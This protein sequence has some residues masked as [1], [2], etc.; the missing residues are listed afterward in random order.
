MPLTGSNHLMNSFMT[1]LTF[2]EF[3]KLRRELKGQVCG[4]YHDGTTYEGE[5]FAV[6]LRWMDESMRICMRCIT[7]SIVKSTLDHEELSG[8]L[9]TA[10]AVTMGLSLVGVLAWMNDAASA[11][12]SAFT[13]VLKAAAPASNQN[14][15]L[16]HTFDHVGDSLNTPTLDKAMVLYSAVSVTSTNS[17]Q[18][19]KSVTGRNAVRKA[20]TRWNTV[21]DVIGGSM[22]PAHREGLLLDWALELVERK[23]CSKTARKLVKML[24]DPRKTTL[25]AVELAVV[26]LGCSVIPDMTTLIQGGG[27]EFM[28]AFADVT[29]MSLRLQ[30]PITFELKAELERIAAGAPAL[31]IKASKPP[32][33]AQEPALVA[34]ALVVPGP[35]MAQAARPRRPSAVAGV[36]AATAAARG[37]GELA[38]VPAVRPRVARPTGTNLEGSKAGHLNDVA[39]LIEYAKS[40]VKPASEYLKA[41]LTGRDSAQMARMR[42]ARYFDPLS[43]TA[44]SEIAVDDL[45]VRF[46]FFNKHPKFNDLPPFIKR[47]I[48]LCISLVAEIPPCVA[49]LRS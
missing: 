10:I 26:K 16:G 46:R 3:E 39:S 11:N 22:Y 33:V 5:A 17:R 7:V 20:A 21:F 40:V 13:T 2:K 45:V 29:A 43:T 19:F 49:L 34:P 32:L 9:I 18:V 31:R 37:D 4:C 38:P 12:M 44:P 14:A 1:P 47:E 28:T 23:Y 6:V 27:L 42:A 35:V 8:E 24:E 15:C 30:N 48:P 41:Q 36:A 25:L